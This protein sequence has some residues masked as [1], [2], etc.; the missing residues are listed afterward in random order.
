MEIKTQ[1]ELV[2]LQNSFPQRI[3]VIKFSADWCAPCKKIK[4]IW[5]NWLETVSSNIICIDIDI[6]ES[7]DLYMSFKNKKIING[8]PAI[9]AF[10]GDSKR[11]SWFLPDDIF[12]PKKVLEEEAKE[13]LGRCSQKAI[14]I[15]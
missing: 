7:L 3:I 10:Y 6:D 11:E 9:L 15:M 14:T 8:I 5:D 12:S 13:F 1:A 4:P 2:N